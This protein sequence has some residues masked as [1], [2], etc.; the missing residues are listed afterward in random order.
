[1]VRCAGS[2]KNVFVSCV[3]QVLS[4][5]RTSMACAEEPEIPEQEVTCHDCALQRNEVWA[6]V[7]RSRSSNCYHEAGGY[8]S[9]IGLRHR[10]R[11]VYRIV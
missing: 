4:C 6:M 8:R 9:V 3:N 1:M 2:R 7:Q 10:M 5:G 11:D